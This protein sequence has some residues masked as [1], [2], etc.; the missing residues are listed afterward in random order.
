MK[1]SLDKTWKQFFSSLYS[2]EFPITTDT[3]FI[4]AGVIGT[5]E[6][7]TQYS[8][9]SVQLSGT[10]QALCNESQITILLK[11]PPVSMSLLGSLVDPL[12]DNSI[13]LS[14]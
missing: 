3:S 7:P 11:V 5:S 13:D 8:Q 10:F 1:F 6:G 9:G 4:D 14:A 12:T 2:G